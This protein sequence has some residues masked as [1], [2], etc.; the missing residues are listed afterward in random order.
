MSENEVVPVR[1]VMDLPVIESEQ[2]TAM[3]EAMANRIQAPSGDMIRITQDKQFRLPNG[4]ASQGPIEAVIV[5]FISANVFYKEGFDE[6]KMGPPDCFALN[7]EPSLLVP[8]P[9]SPDKQAETCS[10]CPNNQWGTGPRGKGKACKNTRVLAVMPP[11]ADANT[12]PWIIKVSPTAIKGFDDY[13]RGLISKKVAPLQLVTAIG[14]DKNVKYPSLTFSAVRPLS[15]NEF[16][17]FAQKVVEANKRLL[18]E[19]DTS[20]REQKPGMGRRK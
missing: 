2:A 20:K 12:P 15:A 14:F 8:S 4:D 18:T 6:D 16:P 3:A 19:P 11:D 9:R 5:D 17:I 10:N 7:A 1:Q 13:V